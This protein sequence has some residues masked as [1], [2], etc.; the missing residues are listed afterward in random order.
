M[1]NQSDSPPSTQ[2]PPAALPQEILGVNFDG[3]EPYAFC[4]TLQWPINPKAHTKTITDTITAAVKKYETVLTE[5]RQ[6]K[7]L[8]TDK[9][10]T[11]E[12]ATIEILEAALLDFVYDDKK[13]GGAANDIEAGPALLG[14]LASEVKDFLL[15]LG[16]S[17]GAKLSQMR[18]NL[19][20]P[21]D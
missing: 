5:I 17:R 21:Q 18:L 16:G 10:N 12:T 8:E 11:Y 7:G 4:G 13:G 20:N 9:L 3:V 6:G 15:I 19:M 14:L 2:Q 1:S